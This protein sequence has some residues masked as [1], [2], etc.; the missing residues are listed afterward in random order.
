MSKLLKATLYRMSK[1]QGA[2]I[3]V[4]ITTLAA[5]L[6]YV[7][8]YMT[9]QG[10]I[11]AEQAGSVTGLGD[12]M[13][14]WLFG[15]LLT[16]L[17]I[18]SDF[19][20]KTIHGA[21]SYGRGR[22]VL[23]YMLVYAAAIFVLVLPYTLG[24]VICIAAGVDMT[25]AEKVVISAYLYNVLHAGEGLSLGKAILSYVALA[26]VYIGQISICIPVAIK[27]KKPIAVTAFGFFF[28]MITALLA[29]LA[30]KVTVLDSLYELTPY[31]YTLAKIR[32]DASAGEMLLGIFVSLVFTGL[33]GVLS[34]LVFRRAAVK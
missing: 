10:S 23:N 20:K 7:L 30:K 19:E 3:A 17:I 18:G 28:G 29:T 22:I 16:G 5:V 21:I 2:K 1:S 32:A 27:V 8:A 11:L 24:S 33:M 25:G 15:P 34:W 12:A 31:A 26:F 6:Y 4:C 13:V 14:L 9:G